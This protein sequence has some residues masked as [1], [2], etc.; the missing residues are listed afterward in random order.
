MPG[1]NHPNYYHSS[2]TL[3]CELRDFEAFVV[4]QKGPCYTFPHY[5]AIIKMWLNKAIIYFNYNIK[6]GKK[7]NS[8]NCTNGTSYLLRDVFNMALPV[9]ILIDINSKGFSTGYLF[10]CVFVYSKRR[11]F[12]KLRYNFCLDAISINSVFVIFRASLLADKVVIKAIIYMLNVS[13]GKRQA[14]IICVH[15]GFRICQAMW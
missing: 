12:R 11:T 6:R 14:G 9:Y 10:Y 4:F 15:S 8:F 1:T 2:Q 5:I 13:T 7:P 3:G